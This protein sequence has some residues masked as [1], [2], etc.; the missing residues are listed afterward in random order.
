M[1]LKES[2][3]VTSCAPSTGFPLHLMA[4][5]IQLPCIYYPRIQTT[6]GCARPSSLLQAQAAP[7]MCLGCQEASLSPFPSA[8]E[9]S[10]PGV[11]AKRREPDVP[12]AAALDDVE[13]DGRS[14]FSAFS[15]LGLPI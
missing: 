12:D 8:G 15:V 11:E 6:M 3:Y 13:V 2:R 9:W 4:I 1:A 14:S 7:G 10:G 5:G